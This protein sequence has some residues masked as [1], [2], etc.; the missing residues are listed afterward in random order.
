MNLLST[1]YI[2]INL[3]KLKYNICHTLDLCKAK[4]LNLAPVVKSICASQPIIDC[5]NQTNVS[6]IA[7]SRLDNFA[8]MDTSK[9]KF[10]IRP[11]VAAE[12]EDVV[13]LCDISLQCDLRSIMALDQAAKSKNTTH[14][15]ILLV[16]LGDLRDGIFFSDESTLLS[17]GAFIHSSANLNLVGIATNY[18]CFLGYLP[19]ED[20]MQE[21]IKIHSLLK[22]FYDTEAPIVS[23]GNSS[24]ASILLSKEQDFPSEFN[25]LRMG[26]AIMLG[27]DPADNTF[28]TGFETDVF[29]LH[30]PLIEVYEKKTPS[31][32]IMRRGVLNIGKQDLQLDHIIP[33]DSRIKVLGGCSDECVVDLTQA[34]DIKSGDELLFDLEYGALMTA[35]A[36]SFI[37]KKY[38]E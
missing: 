21:L 7:D 15:I 30:V 11:S 19:D 17:C 36:G 18:N 10:L 31:Q 5:F 32:E 26:E 22:P 33:R 29:T 6:I 38:I 8:R 4:S 13:S 3:T 12:A 24:S 25:Q 27:R 1:V 23:G 37:N 16:D 28:I 2:T 35:F 20:N 34:P 9:S 14:D